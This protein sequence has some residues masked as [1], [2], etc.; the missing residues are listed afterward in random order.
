MNHLSR[1][2]LSLSVLSSLSATAM[3]QTLEEV[4][5]TAQK[6]EQALNDVSIAINAFTAEEMRSLRV[7]DATEIAQ[8]LS[9]ID[10]KGTLGGGTQL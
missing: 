5:V 10:I 1:Y 4:V 6:R 9:N 7:E 3:S 8:L 2:S